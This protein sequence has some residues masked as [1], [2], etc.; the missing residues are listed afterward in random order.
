MLV[1]HRY[2]PMPNPFAGEGRPVVNQFQDHPL[3]E[4]LEF[5]HQIPGSIGSDK[6]ISVN[7]GSSMVPAIPA[8]VFLASACGS[9]LR[10]GRSLVKASNT[11]AMVTTLASSGMSLPTTPVGYPSPSHLSWWN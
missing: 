10:Y 3:I 8:I 9:A 7:S 6:K 11:S 2:Q 4:F 1:C 5:I